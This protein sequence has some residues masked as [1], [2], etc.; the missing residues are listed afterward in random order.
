MT[1]ELPTKI[2]L[3][4]EDLKKLM[5][6]REKIQ[7]EKGMAAEHNKDLRENADYDYWL[8]REQTITARI[9]RLTAE[10]ETLYKKLSK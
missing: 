7:M 4:R 3:L 5:S 2:D 10:I 9:R 6:Q 8:E 1:K